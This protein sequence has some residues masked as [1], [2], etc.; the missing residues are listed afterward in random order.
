MDTENLV[1]PLVQMS[2]GT[3]RMIKMAFKGPIHCRLQMWKGYSFPDMEGTKCPKLDQVIEQN[4]SK[5]VKEA[6]VV[7]AKLQTLTPDV[8]APLVYILEK[9]QKDKLT[10]QSAAEAA[11]SALALLG[12]ASAHI[13]KER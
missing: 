8:V 1:H 9:A 5:E 4:L 3:T 10:V 7:A 2:E 12:N 6:D 11:K 13:T